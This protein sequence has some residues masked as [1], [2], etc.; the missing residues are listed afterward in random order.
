MNEATSQLPDQP[1]N[2]K[3]DKLTFHY[4]KTGAYRPLHV[5]GAV[6]AITPQGLISMSLYSE[7][8]PIPQ[9][10]THAVTEEGVL[11]AEISE[12]RRAK[13]GVIR[14]VEATLLLSET[15]AR[16]IQKWLEERLDELERLRRAREARL[17]GTAE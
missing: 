12:A 5:D 3:V 7:H 15:V 13:E 17:K 10:V 2:T 8:I 9:S 4:L 14:D 11:G 16:S 6:G 1:G